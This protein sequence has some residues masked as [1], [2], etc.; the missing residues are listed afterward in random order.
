MTA[1]QWVLLALACCLVEI[2]TAGLWF[3]W[4]ALA[5]LLTALGVKLGILTGLEA[6]LLVFSVFTLAFLFFTRPLALKFFKTTETPS[7][8]K[9]VIGQYGVVT[10]A[11]T[12]LEYGQVKV[13]G[14]IWTAAAEQDLDLDDRIRVVD[15]QGVKLIVEQAPEG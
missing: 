10:K 3:L 4:L 5:A 11:I 13:N 1:L 9:A 8:I 6:Q 12:P 14:E 15:V 7:N 2:F